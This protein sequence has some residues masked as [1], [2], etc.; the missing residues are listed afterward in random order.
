VSALPVDPPKTDPDY[1]FPVNL[2]KRASRP[3]DETMTRGEILRLWEEKYARV[4]L[5]PLPYDADN[6]GVPP[7]ELEQGVEWVSR[8]PRPED[9][10]SPVAMTATSTITSTRLEEQQAN[11]CSAA[12]QSACPQDADNHPRD[13][14]PPRRRNRRSSHGSNG[15]GDDD[16]DDDDEEWDDE[17]RRDD[18]ECRRRKGPL[19]N[20]APGGPPGG[21]LGGPPDGPP[22]GPPGGPGAIEANRERLELPIRRND[23]PGDS[24]S[25]M[26]DR[27]RGELETALVSP[28]LPR[29]S[30]ELDTFQFGV[31]SAVTIASGRRTKHRAWILHH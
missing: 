24:D 21:S 18:H 30:A 31:V 5:P 9:V 15:Y 1:A 29:S 2:N 10:P 19:D 25:T 14:R 3:D 23:R 13:S 17:D 27:R 26:T 20:G 12:A 4:K 8:M 7:V 6:V 11:S 16:D 28:S 22:G